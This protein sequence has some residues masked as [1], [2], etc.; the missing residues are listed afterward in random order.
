LRLL[1]A[2]LASLPEPVLPH[3]FMIAATMMFY[4]IAD[5]SRLVD[6]YSND[7]P[8]YDSALFLRNLEESIVAVMSS[9]WRNP[10]RKAPA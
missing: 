7:S 9:K 10:V 6:N 5:Y 4:G 2:R 3:R 8:V 1:R